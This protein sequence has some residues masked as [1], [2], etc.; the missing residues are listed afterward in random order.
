MNTSINVNNATF[1]ATPNILANSISFL[2]NKQVNGSLF[3]VSISNLTAPPSA[4]P[5]GSFTVST[6][7]NNYM[8]ESGSYCCYSVT[9]TGT[10]ISVSISPTLNYIN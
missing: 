3:T 5:T 8:I 6:Y 7:R 9:T 10:L 4:L 2:M 1:T